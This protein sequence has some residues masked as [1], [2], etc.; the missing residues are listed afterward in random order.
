MR[1]ALLA[2]LLPSVL[3]GPAAAAEEDPIRNPR[4]PAAWTVVDRR[5]V[6]GPDRER[7]AE[8]LGVPLER[9]ENV[10]LDAGG[11]PL[12]VNLALCPDVEA[13]RRLE[14]KFVALHGEDPA[15]AVRGGRRV[16]EIVCGNRIAAQRAR[17]LTGLEPPRPLAWSVSFAA[18]PLESSD[19]MRWNALFN[20]LGALRGG[21]E[22]PADAAVAE[23]A[24]GFEFGKVLRVRNAPPPGF[25]TRFDFAPRPG[26]R[27]RSPAEEAAAFGDLPRRA[28]IPRVLV[29]ALV[30]VLPFTARPVEKGL[31][32]AA[33]VA[34]TPAWPAED[35]QALAEFALD[36]RRGTVKPKSRAALERILALVRQKVRYGGEVVGSR[37]GVKKVLE[38]GFGHCWDLSDVFIALCRA[39]GTPARQVGGWIRGVSGH[40]WTEALVDGEGWVEVDPSTSWTG[41]SGDYVPL[42]TSSDGRT[43]FVYF[44]PPT[45]EPAD[46]EEALEDR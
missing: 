34:S 13:A 12:Q 19:G 33:L 29:E 3:P 4:L 39:S 10:R 38:Q 22:G 46:P 9:L 44:G 32:E 37:Y 20:A 43:P 35:L 23:A 30:P 21:A 25:A 27:T 17:H 14:A 1:T 31:D 28:G 2:L 40:V 26:R 16:A 36:D 11:L 15:F 24:R 5:E 45:L 6:K 8:R 7:I 41:V 18:A 42:W